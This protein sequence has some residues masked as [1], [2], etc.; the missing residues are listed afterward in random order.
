MFFKKTMAYGE[1]RGIMRSGKTKQR[2]PERNQLRTPQLHQARTPQ[3]HR[4]NYPVCMTRY[5]LQFSDA[6]AV[7]QHPSFFIQFYAYA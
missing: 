7:L 6:F 3:D 1:E 5:D 2:F 4:L